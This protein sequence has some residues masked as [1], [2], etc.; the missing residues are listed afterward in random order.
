MAWKAWHD[1]HTPDTPLLG[2]PHRADVAEPAAYYYSHQACVVQ[3]SLV[4]H[5][6]RRDVHNV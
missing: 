4:T 2:E 5:W 1:G 6:A 3:C